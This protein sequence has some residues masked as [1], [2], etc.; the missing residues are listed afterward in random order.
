MILVSVLSGNVLEVALHKIGRDDIVQ[1]CIFNVDEMDR[2]V[3][4]VHLDQS[5]FESLK[6]ELGPSR[7]ASLRRDASLD[8]TYDE[9]DMMKVRVCEI[10]SYIKMWLM[11]HIEC[12][13]ILKIMEKL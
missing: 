7:D 11:Y 2:A 8:I 1:Q 9:Q 3:A 6:E 13:T 4:K 12:S 5:G 10:P